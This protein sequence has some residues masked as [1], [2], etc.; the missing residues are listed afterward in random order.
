MTLFKPTA[1]PMLLDRRGVL[2][3]GAGVAGAAL[4][5]GALRAAA[6]AAGMQGAGFYRFALGEA[7]LIAVS[8]GSNEVDQDPHAIFGYNVPKEAFDAAMESRFMPTDSRVAYYHPLFIDTGKHKVLIDTG[9]GE[10]NPSFGKLRARLA[11]AGIAADDIDVVV[12]THGHPDH[13][14]GNFDSEGGALFPKAQFVMSETDFRFWTAE[15]VDLS[16]MKIPEDFKT[17]IIQG[18]RRHLNP[19]KGGIELVGDGDEIVP[20]VHAVMAPGHTPGHMGVLVDG[21]GGHQLLHMVDTAINWPTGLLYPEWYTAFDLDPAQAAKTRRSLL[22]RAA[23]EGWLVYT[24]HFPFPGLGHV[25]HS[26]GAFD[27]VP[28]AWKW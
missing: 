23:S 27:W 17:N 14:W 21:G 5:P 3:L 22:D 13:V 7:T 16:G 28:A 1:N 12:L 8:D 2:R 10:S 11:D 9:W 25:V 24:Y 4:M 15:S 6:D 19:L 26:D 20:G 18:A